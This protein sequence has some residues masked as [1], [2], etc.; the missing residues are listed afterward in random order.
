MAFE[1]AIVTPQGPVLDASVETVVA[2][3]SSGE[4]GVLTGH[5]AFLAP[6]SPGL[7]SCSGPDGEQLLVV[8]GGFAEVTGE[9]MTVLVNAAERPED[10]DPERAEAA[11]ERAV[12][13]MAGRAE[14]AEVDQARAQAAVARAEARIAAAVPHHH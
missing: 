3:G 7:L 2:P 9:R 11:R 13:R 12:A 6:L 10:V 1:L 5:E 8:A 14:E 4:F